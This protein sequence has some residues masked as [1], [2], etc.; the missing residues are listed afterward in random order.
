MERLAREMLAFSNDLIVFPQ[1]APYIRARSTVFTALCTRRGAYAWLRREQA[2]RHW[3]IAGEDCNRV[4]S[5]L[6]VKAF[7]KMKQVLEK[8]AASRSLS[9]A[10]QSY[11]D[12]WYRGPLL[13]DAE[14]HIRIQ[15]HAAILADDVQWLFSEPPAAERPRLFYPDRAPDVT[16]W[17][18]EF[19]L[20]MRNFLSDRQGEINSAPE[21]D[22]MRATEAS[23]DGN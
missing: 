16:M 20:C 1:R 9:T 13:A 12:G 11:L 18:E 22:R 8:H 15:S 17:N 5:D 2:I 4:L 21:E 10:G 6:K 19:S 23:A 7:E 3:G 14:T